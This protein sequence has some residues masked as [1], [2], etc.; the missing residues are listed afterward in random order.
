M[1]ENGTRA[2]QGLL[3]D[4]G[5]VL[6]DAT[7][8]RRWLLQLLH[9]MGL[10][11]QYRSFFKL[12]DC[13][14]LDDVHC[15][16]REYGEAFQAFLLA[17]G[18]TRG[19]IDE[20]E[21]ASQA[22]KRELERGVRPFPGIR[23]VLHRLHEAGMTLGVLSDSESTAEELQLRLNQL[24]IGHCFIAVVSSIDLERTKPDPVCYRAAVAAM[25][26]PAE[27][28]AFIGHDAEELAGARAVGM[29][30]WAFN[31]DADAVADRYLVR[32]D[33]LLQCIDRRERL[34]MANTRAV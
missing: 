2:V 30:A 12:W 31:F 23:G 18:L 15:G 24:G 11:A 32:F 28:T 9:R 1:A 13:D 8:W 21:A 19:Q 34:A 27:S 5:D 20:V 16:R 10:H 7:V 25:G 14:F 22:R 17:A 3:F 29:R 6:Y 4:M 26:L 33:E